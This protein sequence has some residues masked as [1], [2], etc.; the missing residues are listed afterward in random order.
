MTMRC[1]AAFTGVS[2]LALTG[3]AAAQLPM[4][5]PLPNF[6][7]APVA[8]PP[9]TGFPPG[10]ARPAVGAPQAAP[11][12]AAPPGAGQEPPCFKEFLPLRDETQKR[13]LLI[14]AAQDRGSPTREEM[15]QLIKN[16]SVA[17]AKMV[18]F[19]T[20]NHISCGIPPEIVTQ[21]KTGH[22]N[23]LKARQNVCSGAP[24]AAKAAP[25]TPKLSDELGLR[26]IAGPSTDSGGTGTFDTLTG[27]PL[28]R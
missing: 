23:T 19:V 18:K 14:K 22:G 25:A 7:N 10:G 2:L 1:V 8:P 9:G 20:D 21:M 28:A 5:G 12:G 17:E 3:V 11:P 6:D 26:G 24:A 15:C 4:L 13:G 27:N 16:L